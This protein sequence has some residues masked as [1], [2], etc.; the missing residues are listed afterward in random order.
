MQWM[1]RLMPKDYLKPSGSEYIQPAFILIIPVLFK[2]AEKKI[3]FCVEWGDMVLCDTPDLI[4]P[5]L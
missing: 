4:K 3:L 2:T 5:M 1:K